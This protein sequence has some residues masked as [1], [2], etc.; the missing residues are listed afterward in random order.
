MLLGGLVFLF[1]D[2]FLHEI[3]HVSFLV[4]ETIGILAGVLLMFL[5]AGIGMAGKPPKQQSD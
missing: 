5:G 4:S 1:G 3:T 2:R